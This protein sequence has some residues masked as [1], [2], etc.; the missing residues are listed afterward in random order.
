MLRN[1][2]RFVSCTEYA[3][4]NRDLLQVIHVEQYKNDDLLGNSKVQVDSFFTSDSDG[5]R[6]Q[7]SV[8]GIDKDTSDI[9]NFNISSYAP[10]GMDNVVK[11]IKKSKNKG[12]VLDSKII[13]YDPASNDEDLSY[14]KSLKCGIDFDINTD[15]SNVIVD[16]GDMIS[17]YKT[18]NLTTEEAIRS[19]NNLQE[20]YYIGDSYVVSIDIEDR[21]VKY[22]ITEFKD[23]ECVTHETSNLENIFDICP[24]IKMIS[25]IIDFIDVNNSESRIDIEYDEFGIV[26]KSSDNSVRYE[27]V[28]YKPDN[29]DKKSLDHII[30]LHPLY[31]NPFYTKNHFSTNRHLWCQDQII[32][33]DDDIIFVTRYISEL[34]DEENKTL[35]DKIKESESI[36]HP[37]LDIIEVENYIIDENDMS[38]FATTQVTNAFGINWSDSTSVFNGN[39]NAKMC[40]QLER[41]IRGQMA[42]TVRNYLFN[43]L[44]G[45][46]D[47]FE[48]LVNMH[49]RSDNAIIGYT[50][51]KTPY[52]ELQFYFDNGAFDGRKFVLY[53]EFDKFSKLC[54]HEATIYETE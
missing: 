51:N 43:V 24:D 1:Y 3:A 25:S 18:N 15:K 30:S 32:I 52:Y 49:L 5:K 13:T 40:D 47:N 21:K 6:Y 38:N 29:G 2:G 26:S 34:S 28:Y 19:Q 8:R 4:L 44:G 11:M 20:V 42:T 14:H 22:I 36:N 16:D 41:E 46:D 39:D 27:S 45:T 31:L 50:A 33:S 48:E 23:G 9:I 35:L 12:I 53:N 7:T 54:F 10:V 37:I 17:I